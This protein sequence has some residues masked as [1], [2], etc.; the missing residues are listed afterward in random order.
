[1]NQKELKRFG[2]GMSSSTRTDAMLN[3]DIDKLV[4][5]EMR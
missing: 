2:G 4:V 5:S 1:M 3:V